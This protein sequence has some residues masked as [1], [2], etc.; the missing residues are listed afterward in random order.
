LQEVGDSALFRQAY[1]NLLQDGPRFQ[2]GGAFFPVSMYPV[3][4]KF[5]G[6]LEKPENLHPS[7][8]H[9]WKNHG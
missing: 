1:R 2:N 9:S 3:F 5:R 7:I 8:N 6:N 4:L